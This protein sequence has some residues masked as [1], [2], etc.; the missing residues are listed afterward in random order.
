MSSVRQRVGKLEERSKGHTA[1]RLS[2]SQLVYGPDAV[3]NEP[4]DPTMTWERLLESVQGMEIQ[5]VNSA[6][7]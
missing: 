4:Y 1:N 6:T 7:L 2:W 3:D 5:K